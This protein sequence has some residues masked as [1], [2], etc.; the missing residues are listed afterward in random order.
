MNIKE[1]ITR[2]QYVLLALL[3]FI[4]IIFVSRIQAKIPVHIH[5][6]GM[7]TDKKGTLIQK[8]QHVIVF[9]MLLLM[10]TGIISLLFTLDRYRRV[11]I[12]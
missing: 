6:Q 2:K 3:F 7:L 5:F 12:N 11:S 9:S 8:G 4:F 10:L 1:R